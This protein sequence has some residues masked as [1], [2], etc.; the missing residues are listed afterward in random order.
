MKTLTQEGSR[1]E[2]PPIQPGVK[3]SLTVFTDSLIGILKNF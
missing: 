3:G 1:D 2:M